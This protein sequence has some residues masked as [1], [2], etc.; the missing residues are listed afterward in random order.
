M[1]HITANMGFVAGAL[2]FFAAAY[3]LR[4]NRLFGTARVG[5]SLFCTFSLM[6]LL[7]LVVAVTPFNAGYASGI[8]IEVMYSLL[9]L[10]LLISLVH[11]ETLL[12]EKRRTEIKE[13]QIKAELE[14]EVKKKTAYLMRAIEELQAEMDER[15]RA[16]VEVECL[17]FIKPH[18][19]GCFSDMIAEMCAKS[20]VRIL[21]RESS[22]LDE[23][24][25]KQRPLLPIEVDSILI[26][27][28]F[29]GAVGRGVHFSPS[30]FLPS[31]HVIFYRGTIE[32]LVRAGELSPTAMS[33]F[34]AIFGEREM[35]GNNK[36]VFLPEF[37]Q[38][39]Q[40]GASVGT[41]TQTS[42]V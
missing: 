38:P 18:L 23:D 31:A 25:G 4:L 10:L 2:Q 16:D 29:I 22:R 14:S 13:R 41:A 24:L 34:D 11:L 35:E 33:E 39:D 17:N 12:K 40:A 42:A 19:F 21:T 28:R 37:T 32:R 9:S 3:A 30:V 36:Q 15:K 7:H 26:F 6:A 20:V 5:W 27:S 1:S 8:K